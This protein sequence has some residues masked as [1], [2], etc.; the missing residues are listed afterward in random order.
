[1]KKIKMIILSLCL[2]MFMLAG[3]GKEQEVIVEGTGIFYLNTEKTGLVKKEYTIQSDTIEESVKELLR[4]MQKETDC[5]EYVSVFP[6]DVKIED[7]KIHGKSVDLYFNVN[8]NNM[9]NASEVLLRAALV[10]TLT[11]VKDIEFVA[12]F[13]AGQ[14]VTDNK[15]VEIGHLG[16]DDFVQNIGTN[17]HSYEKGEFKLYFVSADGDK[18]KSNNV[19]VRYNSNMSVEKVIVEELLD[20]PSKEGLQATFPK[21]TKVL[22]VSVK[23]SICY[24]NFD[25]DFLKTPS[26][27]DP[28]LMIYS[29]VNSIIEG[30]NASKVQILINGEANVKYQE[31]VD[32]S[33]PFSRNLD[34]V[35]GEK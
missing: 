22:G 4:E 1:M 25:E 11:Q 26:T 21:D 10:Q 27:V 6:K 9:S 5:I 17:L 23:D 18:L 14:P 13:A 28:N 30:G 29:L 20:G 8:Y 24:V 34:I 12:F 2:C 7:W 35:E 32:F 3:C 16:K 31:T 19:S 33:Q 15:G